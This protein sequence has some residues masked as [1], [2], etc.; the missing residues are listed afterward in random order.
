M[1]LSPS[2]MGQI[3][4]PAAAHTHTHSPHLRPGIHTDV[5]PPQPCTFYQFFVSP[6]SPWKPG[7]KKVTS[8]CKLQELPLVIT[9]SRI[10]TC[11]GSAWAWILPLSDGVSTVP[12]KRIFIYHHICIRGKWEAATVV[13]MSKAQRQNL[14]QSYTFCFP[15]LISCYADTNNSSKTR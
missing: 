13:F 15:N 1:T 12:G 2:A 10:R 7:W 5:P 3:F 11:S 8:I 6:W 9:Y 4:A 14:F